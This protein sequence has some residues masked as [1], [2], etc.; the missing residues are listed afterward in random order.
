MTTIRTI[1]AD[2]FREAGIIAAGDSVEAA[3]SDE[4]LRRLNNIYK[5]FF[6]IEL[7]ENLPPINYGDSGLINSYAKDANRATDIDSSYIPQNVRLIFNNDEAETLYLPP[8]PDDGARLAIVD[9]AGN[10]ATYNVVINGNGRK[11]ESASSIT[12]STDSL[13]RE[14]FYRADTGNW[15]RVSDL[16]IDDESPLPGEFDDFLTTALAIR[17]HPRYGAET[18]Q[19]TVEVFNRMRKIFRAR[20]RQTHEMDV[21]DGLICIPSRRN[22]PTSYSRF[23]RGRND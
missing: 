17:I 10:L 16:T 14:W 4:A 22:K 12:L 15:A 13:T 5:S 11:I 6:G 9:N 21:E 1:I 19:E 18:A 3:A 8:S 20:Y 7:G 23:A 2:A